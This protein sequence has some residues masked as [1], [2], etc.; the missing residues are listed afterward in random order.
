MRNISTLREEFHH[1]ESFP[2]FCEAF[3]DSKL[4]PLLTCIT[5]F[6]SGICISVRADRLAV[7]ILA[8]VTQFFKSV[9]SFVCF[10]QS[11]FTVNHRSR[12]WQSHSWFKSTSST[13]TNKKTTQGINKSSCKL[14][15]LFHIR[16]FGSQVYLDQWYQQPQNR[17]AFC[18]LFCLLPVILGA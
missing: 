7:W 3:N 1:C 13:S 11:I 9:Q 10:S 17:W 15:A 4:F 14:R 6:L 16:T 5:F 12:C 18:G 2:C 8:A